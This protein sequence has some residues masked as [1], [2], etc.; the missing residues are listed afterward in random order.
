MPGT[1]AWQPG[2]P[3]WTT[4][5]NARQAGR[6][7]GLKTAPTAEQLAKLKQ[8]FPDGV[9][10]YSKPGVEQAHLAGTWAIFKGDGEYVALE[11]RR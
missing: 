11:P 6:P 2:A 4:S 7:G 9:C 10:D 1:R 8:T 5:S 3:A